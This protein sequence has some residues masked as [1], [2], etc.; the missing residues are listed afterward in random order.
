MS[1][2]KNMYD[3]IDD[4]FAEPSAK[5]RNDIGDEVNVEDKRGRL[6]TTLNYN[7]NKFTESI[8][9]RENP[10]TIRNE[11]M[12]QLMLA[13]NYLKHKDAKLGDNVISK[14]FVNFI[15][16]VATRHATLDKRITEE[17]LTTDNR[18]LITTDNLNHIYGNWPNL[19]YDTREFYSQLMNLI[20]K[21]NSK[22]VVPA[23]GNGVETKGLRLN[24]R[25]VDPSN[26]DS[27][28]VFGRTLP[29]LPQGC[30]LEGTTETLGVDYLHT[31]YNNILRGKVR[32]KDT[33][34]GGVYSS[35]F[36]SWEAAGLNVPLFIRNIT[37][38]QQKALRAQSSVKGELGDIYD[39][40]SDKIYKMK[41]GK[42]VDA[43]DKP[44][45]EDRYEADV[46]DNCEGTYLKNCEMVHTCLLSGDPKKLSG[47]LGKLSIKSMYDVAK[48]EVSKMN[49]TTMKN[50]L[51]TF[52]I[53]SNQY[54]KVEEYVEWYSSLE[55]R[56]IKK[57]GAENGSKT[58]AAILGNN[59]L[60]E[61]IKNV[62]AVYRNNP[63]LIPEKDVELSDLPN[64]VGD[65]RLLYFV[66]P[67]NINRAAALSTQLG[68]LAHRLSVL[69]QNFVSQF[70]A[71]LNWSNVQFGQL[72]QQMGMFGGMRGGGCVED[73]VA[74]MEAIYKQILQEM[75]NNGKDLVDDDKKRIENAIDQIRKNNRQL[76][77]SLNDLKA[78]MR[79]NSTI[80][81]GLTNVTLSDIKGSSNIAL[82]NQIKSFESSINN[83]A[84]SQVNLMTA[85][86]EQVFQPM[87]RLASGSGTTLLRQVRY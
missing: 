61:Y 32:A 11:G 56:L 38:I 41:D 28:T 78:F 1:G 21:E 34:F 71:P 79:L 33:Q 53:K 30:V 22:L 5:V 27:E 2:A 42:L 35:E 74:T 16:D 29:Y 77:A 14:V 12:F 50:L 75:T 73:S 4:F 81:N 36:V 10:E 17:T 48:N 83:T 76:E 72:G 8:N 37:Y 20:S 46:K 9:T 47:C 62:M 58:A 40:T 70:N 24:L 65:N 54:G 26:K 18:D 19:S 57:L 85:L 23:P 80:T 44:M 49:P 3:E 51:K 67:T 6:F 86:I 15:K 25:K 52:D 7:G 55:S 13:K 63:A 68:T 45:D 31:T 84:N 64:K 39:F 59:K 43:N 66:K 60:L 69:P 82:S 87:A